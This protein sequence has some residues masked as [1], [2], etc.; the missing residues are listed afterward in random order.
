MRARAAVSI[1]S[2]LWLVVSARV[3]ARA[4]EAATTEGA[5][6]ATAGEDAEARSLFSA[7]EVAFREGRYEN[8]LD[9][10]QRAYAL[11]RRPALLY[12]IGTTL[13]RLRRDDEA[14]VAFEQ[15][16]R[17]VTEAD[18][19]L[20]IEARLAVLRASVEARRDEPARDGGVASDEGP[21]TPPPAASGS[22]GVGGWILVGV[23][24]ASIVAGAVL[25]GLAVADVAAVEN[26]G[27]GT[28]WSAV[29]DAY[30]RSEGESIAGVVLLGVGGAAAIAG[31]VWVLLPNEPA[32]GAAHL[33]IVPTPVACSCEVPSDAERTRP[34]TLA[35]RVARARGLSREHPERT[36]LVL[37]E[38]ALPDWLQLHRRPLPR[39]LARRRKRNGRGPK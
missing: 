8:A 31:L 7:G 22:D 36:I 35:A 32:Q 2:L 24:G 34:R 11:S 12:N 23:G 30:G 33:E 16:L 29:D 13:D 19:R 27:P 25:L 38:R 14:I 39:G 26:P 6:S 3:E 9:Y 1:A 15:Y 4:Q 21:S 28:Y 18:N 17:E 20:E 10:L 37:A 5:D